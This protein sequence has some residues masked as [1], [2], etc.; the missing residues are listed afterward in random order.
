[1]SC[2]DSSRITCVQLHSAPSNL[3][4]KLDSLS[5]CFI[6]MQVMDAPNVLLSIDDW[7][8]PRTNYTTG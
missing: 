7:L 8:R 5:I 6:L 2:I 1:M 4:E 3:S